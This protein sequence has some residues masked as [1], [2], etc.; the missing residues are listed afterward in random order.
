MTSSL[1]VRELL[2]ASAT[3]SILVYVVNNPGKESLL[4]KAGNYS[5][6]IYLLHI[7]FIGGF[8]VSLKFLPILS[9]LPDF[10]RISGLT[11]VAMVGS[12]LLFPFTNRFFYNPAAKFI[13][14]LSIK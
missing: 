3:F 8:N 1:V 6:A 5:L 4:S 10:V 12:V 13:T 2:L 11:V 7:L 9:A 14:K